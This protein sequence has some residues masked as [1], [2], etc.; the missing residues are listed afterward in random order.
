MS[1]VNRVLGLLLCL[2]LAAC[3]V[4]ADRFPGTVVAPPMDL[5][6]QWQLVG[7]RNGR[8]ALEPAASNHYSIKTDAG[9]PAGTLDVTIQLF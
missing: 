7:E 3:G 5:A 8:Y 2:S 6:G 4:S 1:A 9:E